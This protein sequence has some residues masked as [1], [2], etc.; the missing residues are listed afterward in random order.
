MLREAYEGA[1]GPFIAGISCGV[2]A[3]RF[4]VVGVGVNFD[5]GTCTFHSDSSLVDERSAVHAG[6]QPPV[7]TGSA[8]LT[9]LIQ[10]RPGCG[11]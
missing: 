11:R 2:T 3:W 9:W 7:P 1:P 6:R 8:L 5:L 10:W 4:L